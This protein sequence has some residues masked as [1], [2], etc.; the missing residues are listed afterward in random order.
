MRAF[1]VSAVSV[2]GPAAAKA[3]FGWQVRVQRMDLRQRLIGLIE[4]IVNGLGYELVLLDFA[5]QRRGSWVRL[6]I[7]SE[8]GI[9][10]DDCERVSREVAATL[11]VE[12]PIPYEYRLEV[13]SPG[14]DRPLVKPEHYARCIGETVKI[15]LAVPLNG[16]KR[17]RGVLR[18]IEAGQ[19]LLDLET[20]P[21]ALPLADVDSARVVPDYERELKKS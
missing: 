11:D 3:W 2:A 4:P 15:E 8:N 7:D 21:V 20:E 10:I 17:F 13:S 14:L 19:V 18:G 9:G 16:R 6:Y 1:F 12:D 5:P